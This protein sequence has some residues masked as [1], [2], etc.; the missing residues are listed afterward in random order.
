MA[1]A[2]GVRALPQLPPAPLG[3]GACGDDVALLQSVLVA[4]G[5]LQCGPWH[6]FKKHYGRRTC[7]AVHRCE[8]GRGRGELAVLLMTDVKSSTFE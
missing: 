1:G 5:Y 7:E 4:L 3:F 8:D 2:Q 6:L